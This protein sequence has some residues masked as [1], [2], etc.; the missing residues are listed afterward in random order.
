MNKAILSISLIGLSYLFPVTLRAEPLSDSG[1]RSLLQSI[2]EKRE[3]A[4]NVQADFREERFT[5]FMNNPVT[6]TG[7]VWFQAPNKFRREVKG[8][9][10][11]VAVSDGKQLWIYYPNFK[12]VEHYALGKR[13]P[14]DAAI[15]AIDTA[16]NLGNVEGTF[17]VSGNKVDNGYELELMPRSPSMKRMFQRFDIRL[18]GDQLATR[19][20]MLQPN[21]DRIV[22]DYSNQSRAPIP[23]AIFEFTPPPGASITNPLGR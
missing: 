5:H 11:S 19:T 10:P 23:Q 22:T 3:S 13:S 12:S 6:N 17:K 9:A 15:A 18:N 4:P 2:R 8:S 1:V 7:K 20:E 21:G 14:I 16:L